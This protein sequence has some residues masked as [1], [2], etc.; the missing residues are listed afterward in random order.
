MD[1]CWRPS[2]LRELATLVVFETWLEMC[3]VPVLKPGQVVILDNASF[4][5]GGSIQQLIELSG[6]KLRLLTSLFPR[7]EQD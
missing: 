2:Q 3:L 5:K 7:P 1:N 6:A 4:H